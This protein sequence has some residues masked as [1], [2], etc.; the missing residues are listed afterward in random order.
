L[1]QTALAKKKAAYSSSVASFFDG[2]K[3]ENFSD[4]S[5]QSQKVLSK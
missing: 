4:V 1:K 3:A 2:T 5:S